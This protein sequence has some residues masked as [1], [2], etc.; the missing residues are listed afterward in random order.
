[1]VWLC[2]ANGL[3]LFFYSYAVFKADGRPFWRSFLILCRPMIIAFAMASATK[4]MLEMS[5]DAIG[6]PIMQLA[7]AG[8]F[9][10]VLYA[11]MIVPVEWT[12]LKDLVQSIRRSRL[13]KA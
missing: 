12:L 11:V 5:G 6:G 10:A 3:T 2:I 13:A 4:V 8:L 7:V 1:M 9:G